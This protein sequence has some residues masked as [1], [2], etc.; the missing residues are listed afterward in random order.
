MSYEEFKKEVMNYANNSK[1]KSWRI[2]QAVFNYIDDNYGVA[3][4]VQFK[5]NVDC[6][7]DDN[8]V[9]SFIKLAFNRITKEA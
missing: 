5:E 9:E 7:Y 8:R 6:F 3:R 4:D 1:P 2:G